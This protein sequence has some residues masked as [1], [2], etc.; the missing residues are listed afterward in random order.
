M[1]QL[2]PPQAAS[3]QRAAPD[4]IPVRPP[5]TAAPLVGPA[6]LHT[7][8]LLPPGV[9]LS[10]TD[11]VFARDLSGRQVWAEAIGHNL[12]LLRQ[13]PG[14]AGLGTG[15]DLHPVAP[16]TRTTCRTSALIR[17]GG[18]MS[19]VHT[20]LAPQPSRAPP[21][22]GATALTYRVRHGRYQPKPSQSPPHGLHFWKIATATSI[23]IQKPRPTPMTDLWAVDRAAI[24]EFR[25][26]ETE[27]QPGIRCRWC[28]QRPS[29]WRQQRRKSRPPRPLRHR[30]DPT[31][32]RLP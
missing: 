15:D 8:K 6:L 21:C 20:R 16:S 5:R 29:R 30:S 12:P 28:G 14:T 7:Q 32:Q 25:A 31:A 11:R 19:G 1:G 13:R 4:P 2:S 9:E 23:S 3:I 24:M 18:R 17:V 10:G 26:W 22:A 27:L